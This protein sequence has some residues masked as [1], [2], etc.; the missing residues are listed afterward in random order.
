MNTVSLLNL[1]TYVFI[2]IPEAT[3]NLLIGLLL[4][5]ERQKLKATPA[6][7]GKFLLSVLIMACIPIISREFID[8]ILLSTLVN[9]FIYAVIILAVYR[10]K[11]Y[12]AFISALFFMSVIM[13]TENLYVIPCAIFISNK[14]VLF[15]FLQQ[16]NIFKLVFILPQRIIQIGLVIYLWNINKV[17]I[18]LSKFNKIK[19]ES[20]LLLL[21]VFS[22]Q[23][24]FLYILADN[25][26]NIKYLIISLIG[27]TLSTIGN[28][29]LCK[30]II[31]VSEAV[32]LE[33]L[34]NV[35][36]SNIIRLLSDF[37]KKRDISKVVDITK[38][39]I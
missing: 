22:F 33:K 29:Y 6:N 17:W 15:K 1:F 37:I 14:T 8:V 13:V 32:R 7:V 9:T 36:K 2:L 30:L 27:L 23:G 20:I 12:K 21:V 26:G 34:S 25:L 35:E 3:L 5:G 4:I 10:F 24:L 19:R 11:W 28:I 31:K 16:N 39:I 38:K 18:N